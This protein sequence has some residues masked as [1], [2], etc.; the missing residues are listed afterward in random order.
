MMP[1]LGSIAWTVMHCEQD[2][3]CAG[4][5]REHTGRN[6]AADWT[7]KASRWDAAEATVLLRLLALLTL[8]GLVGLSSLSSLSG[9]ASLCFLSLLST[10]LCGVAEAGSRQER[11]ERDLHCV[12][13]GGARSDAQLRVGV[14]KRM[15]E[16]E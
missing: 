5:A 4:A 11:D 6:C 2:G 16:V 8:L 7:A 1:P 3:A 9:L 13:D 15:T 10:L 14:F 12:V